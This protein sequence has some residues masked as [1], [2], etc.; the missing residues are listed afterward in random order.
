MGKTFVMGLAAGRV[1]LPLRLLSEFWSGTILCGRV[2]K[3]VSGFRYFFALDFRL[4][5]I[6]SVAGLN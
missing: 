1:S 6:D 5:E 4:D 3:P 2:A